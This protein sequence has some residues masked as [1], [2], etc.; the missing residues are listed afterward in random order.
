MFRRVAYYVDR[1]IKGTKPTELPI[2]R[3][4]QF[5]LFVNV[6]TAKELGLNVPPTVLA[7]ADD[8]IE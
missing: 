4:T 1:I 5:E 6:K 2:E 8:V 3:P 7:R